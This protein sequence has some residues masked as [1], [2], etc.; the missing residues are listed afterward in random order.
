MDQTTLSQEIFYEAAYFARH[1]DA[2]VLVKRGRFKSGRDHWDEIGL[3]KGYTPTWVVPSDLDEAEYLLHYPQVAEAID[4]DEDLDSAAGH[5][6]RYGNRAGLFFFSLKPGPTRV[7]EK[8]R[9]INVAPKLDFNR[10]LNITLITPGLDVG[11]VGT[12]VKSLLGQTDPARLNWTVLLYNANSDCTQEYGEFV[13]NSGA[14]VVGPAPAPGTKNTPCVVRYATVKK[15][16]KAV[17]PETDVL[18]VWGLPGYNENDPF[19]LFEGPHV[20]LVHG[21]CNYTHRSI[22]VSIMHGANHV[23]TVSQAAADVLPDEYCAESIANGIDLTRMIPTRSRAEVRYKWGYRSRGWI[24]TERDK[25]VGYIGRLSLEKDPTSAARAVAG[26][27]PNFYCVMIGDATPGDSRDFTTEAANLVGTQRLYN[28]PSVPEVADYL[29][30]FDVVVITSF[31]EG[32]GLMAVEAMAVGCPIVATRVGI[33]PE[34]EAKYG[35]L[36]YGVPE[37][38]TSQELANAVKE[39]TDAGRNCEMVQRAKQVAF[40]HLGE[41]RMYRDW[42]DYLFRIFS[43]HQKPRPKVSV[44]VPAWNESTRIE[45]SLRSLREQTYKDFEVIIVD[46]CSDDD[47]ADVVEAFIQDWPQARLIRRETPSSGMGPA[48]ALNT[49]FHY[50]RGEYSTW[51]SADCWVDPQYLESLV[52]AL[53]DNPEAVLAYSDYLCIWDGEVTLFQYREDKHGDEI[54]KNL[55]DSND[56]IGACWL[57]RTE[58]KDSVGEYIDMTC[59]DLDMHIRMAEAGPFVIVPRVLGTWMK[60]PGNVTT[61][62]IEPFG[63]PQSFIIRAKHRM[64]RNQRND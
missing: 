17:L 46:D 40:D 22:G 10:P 39:A 36:V 29:N 26:L 55:V 20:A 57:W 56:C 43:E 23:L 14:K 41:E 44:V 54:H 51:W 30:A 34:L 8:V 18:L 1:P 62:F 42:E 12:W 45:K 19:E 52:K 33:I 16:W 5:F 47:T 49:G 37:N 24:D 7:E 15:A 3:A 53:D 27:P 28:T 13:L 9:V 61:R 32:Y 60:H 59:E 21:M 2:Q 31:F 50:V 25:F 48:T 63:A 38:A 11:G 58:V 64:R 4:H 6:R 35:Q